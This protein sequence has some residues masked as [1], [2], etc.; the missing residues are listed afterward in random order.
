MDPFTLMLTWPDSIDLGSEV[1]W[2]ALRE[3]EAEADRPATQE[4][5]EEFWA[6]V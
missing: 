1:D 2:E 3:A 4:D 5:W 6:S